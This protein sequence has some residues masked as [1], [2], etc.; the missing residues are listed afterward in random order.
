MSRL[1]APVT[2]FLRHALWGLVL[3]ALGGGLAGLVVLRSPDEGARASTRVAVHSGEAAWPF[4]STARDRIVQDAGDEE[5][6]QAVMRDLGAPSGLVELSAEPTS[7]EVVVELVATAPSE[8]LAV[9]AA[10]AYAEAVVERSRQR[11]E[12]EAAE[13]VAQREVER[14]AVEGR[15]SGLEAELAELEAIRAQDPD[16]LTVRVRQEQLASALRQEAATRAQAEQELVRAD[17][18]RQ[19]ARPA[20]EV[21]V[22]ATEAEENGAFGDPA[23]VLALVAIPL[24]LLGFGASAVWSQHFG[25]LRVPDDT[26]RA[27]GAPVAVL[28]VGPGEE[29][30]PEH[31]KALAQR[32]R[33]ARPGRSWV[34]VSV[35][36]TVADRLTAQLHDAIDSREGRPALGPAG[37][38]ETAQLP[39]T[40]DGRDTPLGL[41]TN[42]V[43]VLVV[44]RGAARVSAL[45]KAADRLDLQGVPVELVVFIDPGAGQP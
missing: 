25:L 12:A 19:A 26:R 21:L 42:A 30:A 34:L 37:N 40:A 4:F 7:G 2:A 39:A 15:I 33:A 45:R 23:V 27:T 13:Q 8:E 31:T 24:F 6:Q 44:A 3:A 22:P 14:A 32:L 28:P 11:R 18:G 43:A 16:S 36:S 20:V 35:G 38:V 1:G 17:Q 9:Q 10:N 29:P 5:L 41:L